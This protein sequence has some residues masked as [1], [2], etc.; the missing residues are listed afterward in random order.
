MKIGKWEAPLLVLPAM[1]LIFVIMIFPLFYTVYCSLQSLDYMQFGGYIGLSNYTKI[2]NDPKFWPSI[3]VTLVISLSAVAVS[4]VLGTLLAIWVDSEYCRFAYGVQLTGLIPWVT[5]MVVAALLWKW[6]FDGES[7]LFNYFLSTLGI[8]PI[9]FFSSASSAVATTVFVIAWRTI[10]Y[11]MVMILAGLK[12]LSHELVEAAAVDGASPAQ[13][14]WRIKLP[15]I[16]TPALIS[17]I[18]LTMSNFNNNTIPMVLTSGGPADATNVIT[19]NLY[20]LGFSYFQ[21]G[22]ASALAFVVFAINILLVMIYIK[23]VK[24]EI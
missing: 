17:T 1:A 11:S 8:R 13:I 7:G 6:V 20:R 23:A 19:L 10:G 24:Y 21:F 4:L 5:S 15:M 14:F 3:R 18:V 16:K 2:F 9:N 22:K 12:G